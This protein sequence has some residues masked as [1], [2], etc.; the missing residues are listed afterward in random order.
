MRTRSGARPRQ[1]M[2]DILK[3]QELNEKIPVGLP[4]GIP[5][6]HKTGDITGVHHDAAL[7]FPPAEK[8]YVLV[9]LTAGINDEQRANQAIARLSRIVWERRQAR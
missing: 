6:A 7:V 9:V 2:L 1:A 5:V 4:A 8:P 3:G